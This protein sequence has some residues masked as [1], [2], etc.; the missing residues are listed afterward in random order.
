VTQPVGSSTELPQ[1]V[2]QATQP[3]LLQTQ[4]KGSRSISTVAFK[5]GSAIASIDTVMQKYPLPPKKGAKK[6]EKKKDAA[7]VPAETKI[8]E[9]ESVA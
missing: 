3:H 7:P 2:H 8:L 1:I 4:F 5:E 6:E 9:P